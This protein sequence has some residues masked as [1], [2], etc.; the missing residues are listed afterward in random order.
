MS[1][2]LF[3]YIIPIKTHFSSRLTNI[4]NRIIY[5]VNLLNYLNSDKLSPFFDINVKLK[6]KFKRKLKV[7]MPLLFHTFIA[8]VMTEWILLTSN[9]VHKSIYVD[10]YPFSLQRCTS[11]FAIILSDYS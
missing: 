6:K 3:H 5:K 7:Y 9:S 1:K 2:M 8:I 4:Q 10:A 11:V